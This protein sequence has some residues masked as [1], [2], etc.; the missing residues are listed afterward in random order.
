MKP[1]SGARFRLAV[2]WMLA[3]TVAVVLP[4]L[5]VEIAGAA[6]LGW[7]LLFMLPFIGG[8]VGGLSVGVCQW[9]VL[10]RHVGADGAWIGASVLGFV[11]AWI[12][13]LVLAAA[14]FVTPVGLTQLKAFLSFAIPT[15]I[16]G[17]SQSRVLRR[18]S[19]RTRLWV[20]ASTVGWTAFVAIVIF[21]ADTLPAAN[22]L[23][24]RLVSGIA[25]YLV[26]STIGATLL[27]GAC[28]G[29]ITGIALAIALRDR[30]ET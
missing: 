25:G 2:E 3:T 7:A 24:G 11:V 10:R 18:W 1:S 15:P 12:L 28:A 22:Q 19:P 5:V 9:A 14:M 13:G 29:A 4:H 8:L 27:G 21:G 20:L 26:A 30:S 23:T 6:L 16:I 17:L